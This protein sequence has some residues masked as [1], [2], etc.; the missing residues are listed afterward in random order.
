M[1]QREARCETPRNSVG[2][3]L[4][5]ASGGRDGL[6][7]TGGLFV[8]LKLEGLD[9]TQMDDLRGVTDE[10]WRPRWK[11]LLKMRS[12]TVE[13]KLWVTIRRMRSHFLVEAPITLLLHSSKLG[14]EFCTLVK[15]EIK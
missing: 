11:F 12:R 8:D 9:A 13:K 6:A 10:I 5:R 14:P 3:T 7:T 1:G 2:D 4:A 15:K